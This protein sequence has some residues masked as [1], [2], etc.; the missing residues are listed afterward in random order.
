MDSSQYSVYDSFPSPEHAVKPSSLNLLRTL[1]SITALLC[2]LTACG[3]S[4]ETASGNAT[5]RAADQTTNQK[6]IPVEK[7]ARDL[8]G[9]IV[10]IT[11]LTGDGTPTDWTFEA[12]EFKQ[13]E[14]VETQIGDITASLVIFM[15]TRN[16]AGPNDDAVQVTGKLKLN[17]EREGGKWTLK[18]IENL[19]F[20]Y[21]VGLSA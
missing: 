12:D 8:V 6:E 19:T 1:L 7:I 3:E 17:Y 11:E 10:A 20:R 18:T 2:A 9:R 21:T 16:N 13:V 5:M 14:I 15:T 4:P